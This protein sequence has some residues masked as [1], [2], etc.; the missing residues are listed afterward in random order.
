M[1]YVHGKVNTKAFKQIV[2]M[3]MSINGIMRKLSC[4]CRG[5]HSP[6]LVQV[7][8]CVD[9]CLPSFCFPTDVSEVVL[10]V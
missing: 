5:F 9:N 10:E 2:A 7:G 3:E 8:I 6:V 1:V 4:L